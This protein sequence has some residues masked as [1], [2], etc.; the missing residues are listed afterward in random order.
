MIENCR[1]ACNQSLIIYK[2]KHYTALISSL[3]FPYVYALFNTQN[4]EYLHDLHN[5]QK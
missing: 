4:D 2:L 1:Y 3:S 5:E